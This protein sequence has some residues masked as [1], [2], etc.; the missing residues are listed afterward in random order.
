MKEDLA[1]N[2][3]T[4]TPP[5]DGERITYDGTTLVVPNRPIIPYILGDGIGV[6]IT[7]AMIQVLDAAVAKAYGGDRKIVWVEVFAGERARERFDQWL[8]QETLDAFT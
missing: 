6:D 5:T 3:T 1:V 4:F 8:P 2:F 7:P